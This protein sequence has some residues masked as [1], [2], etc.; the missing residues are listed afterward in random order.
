MRDIAL[1]I[2]FSGLL[3]MCFRRTYLAPLLWAWVSMMSPHRLTF[4]FA[5]SLP[6]GQIAAGMTFLGL[7]TSKQ[8]FRFPSSA[9]AVLLVAFFVWNCLTALF[10]FNS[11]E[12]VWAMWSKVAKIQILLFASLVLI[13]GKQQINLLVAVVTF[14]VAFYGAKGG[15]F[16]L[17]RGGGGT[18]WGPPG[19]FIEGNN[20]LGVAFVMVIPLLYYLSG[21]VKSVWQ[22]RGLLAAIFFTFVSTLGTHSR[23]ALLAVITMAFFL[24]VKS[25]RTVATLVTLVVVLGGMAAFM[26][27]N[28]TDRMSTISS[29]QDHSAQSRLYTWQMILNMAASNPIFGGGYNVTENP[30][31]WHRYAVTEWAR[32]YSP[33]S[34]YFQALAE[35]GYVGLFLYL[36]IG[37]LTWRLASRVAKAARDGPDADW[38]PPLM[39]MIQVS[40]MGFA[41]GGTFVNLVNYDLPYYLVAIVALVARDFGDGRAPLPQ[42]QPV[43]AAA[44]QPRVRSSPRPPAPPPPPP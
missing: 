18:V 7:L 31:T 8:R 13:G 39:R 20:E 27:D 12:V 23:G 11:P 15:L 41:V 30:A 24:G 37:I 38:V 26:P 17:M 36:A 10:S 35:H 22:R 1:V 43:P 33:H 42:P 9:P 3:F 40:L 28:W 25:K 21:Q 34:V 4:G 2:V 19:S 5:Y 44:A 32:A 6:F 16:T 14:S 29:H